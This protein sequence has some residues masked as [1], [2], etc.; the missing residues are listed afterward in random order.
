MSSTYKPH[1]FSGRWPD[2]TIACTTVC[3]PSTQMSARVL[4]CHAGAIHTCATLAEGHVLPSGQ[5]WS[6]RRASCLL[7]LARQTCASHA[8]K[9]AAPANQ[10]ASLRSR[11]PVIHMLHPTLANHHPTRPRR[12]AWRV[13]AVGRPRRPQREAPL[14]PPRRWPAKNSSSDRESTSG[15]Y[16]SKNS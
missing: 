2:A 3:A 10:L 8:S 9:L 5:H 16:S 11:Q 13:A 7:C 15:A 4:P 6:W 1:A 14:P 12:R